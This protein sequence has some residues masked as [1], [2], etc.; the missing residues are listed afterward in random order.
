MERYSTTVKTHMVLFL[1]AVY[2]EIGLEKKK[3]AFKNEY[4]L[5]VRKWHLF[6]FLC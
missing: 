3:W 1:T 4:G 6:I 2:A 5:V